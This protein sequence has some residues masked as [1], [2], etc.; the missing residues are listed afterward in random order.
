MYEFH[1]DREGTSWR[2]IGLAARLCMELGLHRRE[3]YETMRDP[4]ERHETILLFWSIYVLDRRWAFGTGMP[5][6]L[7]D[8][9]IDPLCPKPE[10][11]SPYLSA[12][13]DFSAIG[14]KVWQS[15]ISSSATGSAPINVEQMEYLDYQLIQWQK[16]VPP[17]LHFDPS[18]IGRDD[19]SADQSQTRAGRRLPLLLYLRRNQMRISIYRPV[20]HTATSIMQH[21]KQ[22]YSVVDIAKDTIRLLTHI[23]STSDLYDTQQMLFNAFL[24]SALA[25]LFLAVAH[26]PALF[27]EPVKEEY[28]M[29]LDLVRNFSR[30]SYVGKRL[31]K[32]VRVLIEVAPKLGLPSRE[33]VREQHDARRGSQPMKGELDPNRS[34]AVAMAGLAGHDVDEMALFQGSWGNAGTETTGSSTSPEALANNLSSLFEAAG[35][36]QQAGNGNVGQDLGAGGL[37]STD[38]SEGLEYSQEELSEILKGLF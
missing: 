35:G 4:A 8:A 32:T 17:H 5:F 29:G 20:L 30:D 23:K 38:G 16:N 15:V 21:K 2:L 18:K 10:G 31:W 27:A 12:M 22:A 26:T 28:Y 1:R 19:R 33:R 11:H 3:T 9:D 13:I 7:Q 24:T 36:Y 25:V 14:S 34:A 6:A 37:F